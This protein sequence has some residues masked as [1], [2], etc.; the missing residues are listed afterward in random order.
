MTINKRRFQ[1][2]NRIQHPEVLARR[3]ILALGV[4]AVAISLARAEIQNDAIGFTPN[5][6]FESANAGEHVDVMSGNVTLTIPIGPRFTLAGGLSYGLTLY[7]NAKIRDYNCDPSV[8][9]STAPCVGTLPPYQIYGLGFS[10]NP[11]RIYHNV[12]DYA[13]VYRLQLEDGSEHFFCD[14]PT[15]NNPPPD[16]QAQAPAENMGCDNYRTWDSSRI[17]VTRYTPAGQSGF[18]GWTAAMPD[19]RTIIFNAVASS[20]PEHLEALVSRIETNAQRPDGTGPLAAVDYTYN[21]NASYGL[22]QIK[23]SEDRVTTLTYSGTSVSINVPKFGNNQA[24]DTSKVATYTLRLQ[25]ATVSNPSDN[26]PTQGVTELTRIEYPGLNPTTESYRFE[27]DRTGETSYGWLLKRTLPTGASTDYYYE[28]Y[29]T[30]KNKPYHTEMYFKKLKIGNDLYNWSWSRFSS[31]VKRYTNSESTNHQEVFS[32]SNP[33]MVSA[34][35]P[36]DN[37]TV[38]T[39]RATDYTEKQ[40]PSDSGTCYHGE[41]ANAWD[42]GLLDAVTTY[43]G[44]DPDSRRVLQRVEYQ[45]DSDTSATGGP[46][47][48]YKY[49]RPYGGEYIP[50]LMSVPQTANSMAVNSHQIEEFT[51]KPGAGGGGGHTRDVV[52]ANWYLNFRPTDQ[53]EYLDGS[54]YRTTHTE[55]AVDDTGNYDA[56]KYMQV[57]DASGTVV[58]RS[59]RKYANGHV[60]C[61]VSR[62]SAQQDTDL[63]CSALSGELQPGDVG[64][65]NAQDLVAGVTESSTV[66]GGD[67]PQQADRK[68]KFQFAANHAASGPSSLVTTKKFDG[69]GWYAMDRDIDY[70]TGLAIASRDAAGNTT[71]YKWDALGRL[72]EIDPTSPEA[73]TVI[74]YDNIL[75]TRVKQILSGDNFVE[76][77]YHYDTLGRLQMTER[78]NAAAQYDFQ[79]TEYDVANRVTR[80]SEWAAQGTADADLKWTTYDYT[81]FV[82]PDPIS[83]VPAEHPDPLGRIHGVT[84]PDDPTPDTPTTETTYDGDTTTVTVRDIRGWA[85]GA[86]A[87]LTSTTIYTNDALGRLVSVNSPGSGADATYAYDELDKLTEAR[88]TDP[89]NPSQVQV[90]RFGYDALG[91]LRTA[92]NPENGTV[93]YVK[94]DQRGNLLEYKDARQTT[95]KAAYDQ[96]DRLLSRSQTIVG[97]ADQ[98]LVENTYD[99]VAGGGA[100]ATAGHLVEQSSYEIVGTGHAL[101]SRTRFGYGTTD[102]S[103]PCSGVYSG[104]GVY[105]GLNGRLTWQSSLL[106]GW[107]VEVRTDYCQDVT[108]NSVITGYPYVSGSGRLRSVTHSVTQNGYLM[109]VQ[110]AGR[111]VWYVTGVHYAPGGVPDTINRSGSADTISLDVRNR[112][113][114]IQATGYTYVPQGYPGEAIPCPTAQA[115]PDVYPQLVG[116]TCDSQ[117]GGGGGGWAPYTIWDSGTYGYDMAGNVTA[118]GNEQYYYDPLNR[119]VHASIPNNGSTHTLDYSFDAFGNMLSQA[120]VT[121]GVLSQTST[122]SYD[123][124]WQTNRLTSHHWTIGG[125][126]TTKNTT[127]DENGNLISE[128]GRAYTLDDQ[129]R[130]RDIWDPDPGRIGDYHYDASGYRVHADA[131]G[132]EAFFLRD[133]SGQ[134]LSEFQRPSG[135][136][137][138]PTWNKDYVYAMGKS[139]AL[140]QNDVPTAPGRPRVTS[141]GATQLTLDWDPVLDPDI[142]AYSLERRY[143]KTAS[144]AETLSYLSITAPSH[145]YSDTFASSTVYLKYRLIAMDSAGNFSDQGPQLSV[146]PNDSTPPAAPPADAQGHTL[147]ATP[148]NRSVSLSWLAVPTPPEDDIA[149]YQV[150]V[151]TSNNPIYVWQTLNTRPTTATSYVNDQLPDGT[152]LQNGTPYWYHVVTVDSFQRKSAATEVVSAAPADSV[153]PGKLVEVAAE[154]DLGTGQIHITW[155]RARETDIAN[156][157][158]YRILDTG[159]SFINPVSVN[160]THENYSYTDSAAVGGTINYYAVSAVDTS[161]LESDLS[162]PVHARARSLDV[163]VPS[164]FTATFDITVVGPTSIDGLPGSNLDWCDVAAEDDD[165]VQVKLHWSSVTGAAEYRVYRKASDETTYSRV[166]TVSSTGATLYDVSDTTLRK[167]SYSYYVVAATALDVESGAPTVQWIDRPFPSTVAV[168]NITATDSRDA[169]TTQNRESRFVTVRWSRITEPALVGYNVYRKCNFNGCDDKAGTA[170]RMD[171]FAC[172]PVWAQMNTVPLP[173]EVRTFTDGE[174]G[175]LQGCFIYGV[176]PVGPNGVEGPMSKIVTIDTTQGQY[177]N[178]GSTATHCT[179]APTLTVDN[180]LNGSGLATMRTVATQTA[181]NASDG[182]NPATRG[183]GSPSTPALPTSVHVTIGNKPGVVTGIGTYDT[184]KFAVVSWSMANP[185]TNFLG[186]HV[187]YAGSPNG[188]WQRL[189]RRPVAWWERHYT[190]QGLW[191]T[192]CTNPRSCWSFRVVAVDMDGN[193]SVPVPADNNPSATTCPTT[194][195]PPSNLEA[196]APTNPQQAA[197]RTVLTWDSSAVATSYIVYRLVPTANHPF[198]YITQHVAAAAGP[199][200]TYIEWGDPWWPDMNGPQCPDSECPYKDTGGCATGNLDA[201]FVTAVD[202]SGAESPRSNVVHWQPGQAPYVWIPPASLPAEGS[203]ETLLACTSIADELAGP[204]VGPRRAKRSLGL[205]SGARIEPDA[206]VTAPMTRLGYYAD[207]PWVV[208]NLYTDHLGSVRA[209]VRQG[210]STVERHDYFPFGEEITPTLSDS[211]HRYTG[212]E[213]D[214]E[215]GLDY[216]LARYLSSS[217]ARSISTDPASYEEFDDAGQAAMLRS[218][219]RWNRYSYVLNNPVRFVD[220]DGR[221]VQTTPQDRAKQID[222]IKKNLTAKEKAAVSLNKKGQ[223]Q[224]A[225]G[226]NGTSKAFASLARLVSSSQTV[227]T[228][229]SETVK[230]KQSSAPGPTALVETDLQKAGGGATV[231]PSLSVSGDIEVHIDPRGNPKGEPSSIVMAHELFGH[232]DDLVTTGRSSEHTATI[233]ENEIRQEQGMDPRPVPP[234]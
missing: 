168:R 47:L 59:E 170:S 40:Q 49:R 118:I 74:Y 7:Y 176:R 105:A 69:L 1:T 214:M 24:L 125:S 13:Y 5:H 193:E 184:S 4:L 153:K 76:T 158:V 35:D 112:P 18:Q 231:P 10:L 102:S 131:H 222:L 226:F 143:K 200:Q 225:K 3:P 232:A 33:Y 191:E 42:D 111:S 166:K 229:M 205:T 128:G 145:T 96:A 65:V 227:T 83:G 60:A 134:V 182:P 163:P 110:D 204:P 89:A 174:T 177:S 142:V 19:G 58:S 72:T 201:Y 234:N 41:C 36:S 15:K 85:N 202:S 43:A 113:S 84:L 129:G 151:S 162:D 71:Q 212:H 196:S 115:N 107:G 73:A 224:I 34:L 185:P 141:K 22:S 178:E 14:V 189:T 25:G 64:T 124:E 175:G 57:T 90:R 70:N 44:H 172:E 77:V 213:R 190:A 50:G 92:S 39:F 45:W 87:N 186:V 11:G 215:S 29:P 183:V 165:I 100:G 167:G 80:K 148:G 146:Y 108:G 68:T 8:L 203:D 159:P 155:K 199:T 95:F 192:S 88:L 104:T 109:Q 181:L 12:A 150:E 55:Y 52:S 179:A 91:R 180:E 230:S 32:K 56:Y 126:T 127:Y 144:S 171:D 154:P 220:P 101:V 160:G 123:V 198:F 164:G 79:K 9:A 195:D 206:M 218:P 30:S 67:D 169:Y 78:R 26:A 97:G 135:S 54:L 28:T 21:N 63:D 132:A 6:V 93:E 147:Y 114:R 48:M 173:P 121:T 61:E 86:S 161:G 53:I 152:Q 119:L 133:A 217:L 197:T 223:V 137:D 16:H 156:Y 94:Y 221:V 17:E 138:T 75:Q 207:P 103:A 209:V 62:K 208:L 122:R 37:L 210:T 216:M 117:S 99:T 149:G 27:Y 136:T 98:T 66:I 188:P 51:T 38:Y 228:Y 139:F 157:R 194:P 219:Q 116:Y 31:T 82:D 23:D 20:D 46:H 2:P 106:T 120:R 211:T 81:I 233:K 130:L 140:V 187:E